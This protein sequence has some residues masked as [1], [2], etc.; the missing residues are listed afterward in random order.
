MT[1][2]LGTVAIEPNRWGT[3]DPSRRPTIVLDDWLGPIATAGFDGIE[4]WEGH[5]TDAVAAGTTP[6]VEV[7][8]SYASF[9]DEDP[10]R[11]D[12]VGRA[13]ARTS[14][15]AVKINVGDDPGREAAYTERLAAWL[16][17][18]DPAVAVLCECHAGTIAEDPAV[19][20]RILGRAGPADRVQAVVHSH[21]DADHLR[22]RF[23]AYGDRITH[24]HVNHLDPERLTAPRLV[25]VADDLAATVALLGRL[26]FD[27]SWTIEL[28]HGLLTVDDHPAALVEQAADDLV[29]LRAVL[30]R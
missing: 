18:L 9:D 17:V 26:G 2:L 19:A 22:A 12:A 6:P 24:V 5:L 7:F 15:R 14:S 30:A 25:E 27:G 13:V 20:A 29:V 10:A 8:N 1:V 3:V 11:R 4:L 23:D 16:D 21:E 28:V